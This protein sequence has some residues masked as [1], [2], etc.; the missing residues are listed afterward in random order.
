MGDWYLIGLAAGL[1]VAFGVVAAG[2]VP[3]VL[4][5]IVPAVVAGAVTGYLL[6]DVAEAVAG[7]IGGAAGAFGATPIVAGALRRGGTRSGLALFVALGA[8]AIALVAL[9]P[10]AGYL[11]VLAVPALGLRVRAKTPERHAGL[12]TLAR[13]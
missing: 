7:G 5:A 6:W 13:D 12:R 8:V 9:I 4:F 1:G 2:I 3:R 10:V 11:A